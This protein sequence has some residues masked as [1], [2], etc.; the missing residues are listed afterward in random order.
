MTSSDLISIIIP[1]KNE[2]GRIRIIIDGLYRQTYRSPIE[3][4]FVDDS[5]TDGT[6]EEIMNVIKEYSSDDFRVRLLRG[7]IWSSQCEE[8]WCAE[9]QW[10]I[11]SILRCRFR[12]EGRSRGSK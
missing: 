11:H 6:V 12:P 9:C 1:V 5:S 3:V 4:I 7:W 2:R 10:Q 8:Y